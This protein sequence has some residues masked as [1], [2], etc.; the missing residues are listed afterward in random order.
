MS[1][2]VDPS[3]NRGR[4]RNRNDK[5]IRSAQ[6]AKP[7][8][9]YYRK[10]YG[11]IMSDADVANEQ[12][13]KGKYDKATAETQSKINTARGNY[14]A[15][16][17]QGRSDINSAYDEGIGGIKR[18]SMDLVPVR[19]V[20]RDKVEATYNVPR[21]FAAEFSNNEE[22]FTA[23]HGEFLNVDVRVKGGRSIQGQE[24]H[25]SLRNASDLAA[26]YQ[27]DSDT[28]YNASVS[29]ANKERAAQIDSFD[30]TSNANLATAEKSWD[31]ELDKSKKAYGER[32]AGGKAMY[33]DSKKKYNDSVL[34][35]NEGLLETPTNQVN[36]GG[37][38]QDEQSI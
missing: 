34:G 24:I 37:K 22:L 15:A 6:E 16:V 25:D 9:T 5:R 10:E 3:R 13:V 7:K 2:L 23:Q 12:T 38:R 32:V 36:T 17:D 26:Q 4:D 19:V 21:D 8:D 35:M 18:G 27:K 20:N 29:N 30:T 1:L 33:E 28:A 11:W 31:M 14:N